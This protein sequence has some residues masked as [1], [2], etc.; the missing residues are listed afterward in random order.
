MRTATILLPLVLLIPACS[1][2]AV[3]EAFPQDVADAWQERYRAQDAAGVAALYTED[4]QLLPP[5]APVVEGRVAIQEFIARN[6]RPGG[7]P[8]EIATVE[9]QVFEDYAH[10]Q[11]S[12]RLGEPGNESSATGKFLE[13]WKKVDGRWLIHREIWNANAP[14]PETDDQADEPA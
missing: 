12:F 1:G 6:F 4:A 13:L 14:P 9:T 11:G 3:P 5:D 8:I 10:R 7:A 2:R